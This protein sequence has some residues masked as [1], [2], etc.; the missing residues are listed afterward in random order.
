MINGGDVEL[1]AL[2]VRLLAVLYGC[3]GPA[4]ACQ[5]FAGVQCDLLDMNKCFISALIHKAEF[6]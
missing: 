2:A 1:L 6:G 5:L 3:L 4:V